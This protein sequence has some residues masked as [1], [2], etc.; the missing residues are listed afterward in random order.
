MSPLSPTGRVP[1]P[2]PG[3]R[4]TCRI[5]KWGGG[6]HWEYTGR[7]LGEDGHGAW[8]GFAAGTVFRRPG[9]EYVAPYDQA[10]LVPPGRHWL[11]TFHADPSPVQVYVDVATPAVWEGTDRRPVLTAVD[12]DLDVVQGRGGRVWV[13]D[14][15]EFAEHRST[16]GYPEDLVAEA[17]AAC[18]EAEAAL[19]AKDP[20]FDG[21]HRWWL[22]RSAALER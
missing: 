14:E 1:S 17:L 20:P 22:Q 2:Q 4:V 9:A 21:T 6:R 5:T 13:D 15:D 12:L 19:V 10:G 11:A 3:T 16:L 18:A 8:L 7:W